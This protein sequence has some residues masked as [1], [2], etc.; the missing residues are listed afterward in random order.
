MPSENSESNEKS[1]VLRFT[2]LLF[3][4]CSRFYARG[5]RENFCR[6]NHTAE[7]GI[8]AN[9]R[10]EVPPGWRRARLGDVIAEA[11]PGFACGEREEARVVQ[12]RMNNVDPRGNPVWD[13]VTRV[14]A[15]K[16]GGSAG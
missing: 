6:V 13:E 9:D 4:T 8:A 14:P 2:A 15:E 11:Q 10:R 3:A 1:I 12:L 16:L 7:I 5:Q